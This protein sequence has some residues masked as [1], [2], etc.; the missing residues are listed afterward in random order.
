MQHDLSFLTWTPSS[1]IG[2]IQ[3]AGYLGGNTERAVRGALGALSGRGCSTVIVDLHAVQPMSC[4]GM[5]TLLAT[6][7][8]WRRLGVRP[9][10]CGLSHSGDVML[11][12]AGRPS[13]A[14]VFRD[15]ENALH[16]LQSNVRQ[17][18]C[19]SGGSKPPIAA[20]GR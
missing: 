9:V 5:R 7:H 18:D 8:R 19:T 6:V 3:L 4:A 10:L 16:S 20:A 13:W 14:P 17:N 12:I 1:T 15:V 2:V 11:E